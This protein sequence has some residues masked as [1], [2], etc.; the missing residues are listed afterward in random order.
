MLTVFVV[1][2]LIA[3][4]VSFLCSLAEAALLSLSPWRLETLRARGVPWAEA[5][6]RM[7]DRIGRPMATILVLNT[8]AHTGGATIAGGAFEDVFGGRWLWAFS[9]VFTLVVLFGTEI[10]PKTMGVAHAE[11][12]APWLVRGLR[13]SMVV[14]H[15]FVVLSEA[16]SGWIERGKE[17][18]PGVSREDIGTLTRLARRRNVIAGE[19]EQIIGRAL[20]MRETPVEQAMIP[21]EWIVFLRTSVPTEENL[22]I[23]AENLHTRYPVSETEDVDGVVG[24][25]NLKEIVAAGPPTRPLLEFLRPVLYVSRDTD[26]HSLLRLF[27]GGRHHLAIVKNADGLI[28][29]MV[30]VEDVLE[31]LVGEIEDEFDGGSAEIVPL[32]GRRWRVGGTVRVAT[33]AERL[34]V[35]VEDGRQ[36]LAEWMRRHVGGATPPGWTGRV[37]PLRVSARRVREGRVVEAVVGKV[38]PSAG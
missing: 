10:V 13:A 6:L 8:I 34:G 18:R 19:Q 26:L 33:I 32:G 36:T 1:S 11:A 20:K 31:E 15:P 35:E 37:G 7:R 3:I 22:K 16:L 25:V 29:G 12:A 21:R 28:G 5:W 38:D 30:T 17:E 27:I 9:L 24:Y 14:L 2:T 4:V 23:A